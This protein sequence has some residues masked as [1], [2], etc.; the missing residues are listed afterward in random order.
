MKL[1]NIVPWGRSL[2]EYTSMFSLNES[3]FNKKILGCGDGP[4]CFNAEVTKKG[5]DIVSV[6]PVYQFSANQIRSRIDEVYPQIMSE[7]KKIM[8]ILYGRISQALMTW[9]KSEWL[10]WKPF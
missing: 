4:A 7:M 3:D 5:G 6:D 2:H 1:D 8:M 10:Q 9:E